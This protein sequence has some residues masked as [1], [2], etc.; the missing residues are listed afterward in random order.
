MGRRF[1]LVSCQARYR[2]A[3]PLASMMRLSEGDQTEWPGWGARS[4]VTRSPARRFV[5]RSV[6]VIRLVVHGGLRSVFKEAQMIMRGK[7]VKARQRTGRG[8]EEQRLN[9]FIQSILFLSPTPD[10]YGMKSK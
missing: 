6:Q 4:P 5:K 9:G 1:N 7:T 2:Q 3:S 8:P 10:F